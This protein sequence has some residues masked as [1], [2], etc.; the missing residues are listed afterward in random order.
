MPADIPLYYYWIGGIMIVIILV[1]FF[2]FRRRLQNYF[3]KFKICPRSIKRGTVEDPQC[4][5]P[6]RPDQPDVQHTVPMR[7]ENDC[8]PLRHQPDERLSADYLREKCK[9]FMADDPEVKQTI[10]STPWTNQQWIELSS[11]SRKPPVDNPDGRSAYRLI[12]REHFNADKSL[13]QT[14]ISVKDAGKG[15]LDND[16]LKEVARKADP[17]TSG[18]PVHDVAVRP[19]VQTSPSLPQTNV[20]PQST[21]KTIYPK[22]NVKE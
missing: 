7:Q 5:A 14:K 8:V 3:S 15:P 13:K 6:T 9:I 17:V 1:F 4:P 22:I 12:P 11:L 19:D 10:Y 2:C 18:T 21:V 16:A 20:I